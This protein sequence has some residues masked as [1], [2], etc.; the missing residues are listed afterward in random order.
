MDTNVPAHS[1]DSNPYAAPAAAFDTPVDLTTPVRMSWSHRLI[2]L[3][4]V[5]IVISLAIE[6]Y[7]HKSIVGSGQVFSALGLAIAICAYRHRDYVATLFGGS[8]IAFVLL[9]VFLVNYNAWS[10][11]EGDRPITLLSFAYA[12][13]ALPM[14]AWLV[15]PKRKSAA[16]NLLHGEPPIRR[17][18]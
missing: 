8:A 14:S 13:C 3:L 7:E 10:P 5:V 1:Y 17:S 4:S 6:S 15:S 9:I 12:A 18:L 16:M 2:V 11:S